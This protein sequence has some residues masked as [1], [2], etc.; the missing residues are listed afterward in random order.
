MP[1]RHCLRAVPAFLLPGGNRLTARDSTAIIGPNGDDTRDTNGQE[2]QAM[3]RISGGQW[4]WIVALGAIGWMLF[5]PH[6]GAAGLPTPIS[7]QGATPATTGSV[8]DLL[9][10]VVAAA[11]GVERF[12]EMCWGI[13]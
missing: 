11:T 1:G 9:G 2:E 6:A 5:Q 10:P 12:I 3:K 7:P 4:G 13:F 8:N